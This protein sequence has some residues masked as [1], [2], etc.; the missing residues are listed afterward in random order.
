LKLSIV[1][2]SKLPFLIFSD[3][4]IDLLQQGTVPSLS[5]CVNTNDRYNCLELLTK[6]TRITITRNNLIDDIYTNLP[7]GTLTPKILGSDLSDHLPVFVS[8]KYKI[9][10][11]WN[12]KSCNKHGYSNLRVEN[13]VTK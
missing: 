5:N 11:K 8:I 2:N 10:K 12:L 7:S 6:L 9:S 13:F 3:I 1:V 4:N